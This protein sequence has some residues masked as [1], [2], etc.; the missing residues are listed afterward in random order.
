MKLKLE[1]QRFNSSNQTTH[2]ELSQYTANDKPTYLIDYN[3]DM[4]KIDTAIYGADARSQVNAGAIGDLTTLETTAKSDL[5]SAVN[6]IKSATDTNTSNIATNTS[7]ISTLGGNIG[8]MANLTTTDK[9]SLVGAINEVDAVNQTQNTNITANTNNINT[10]QTEINKFNLSNVETVSAN[11]CTLTNCS[12]TGGSGF[13]VISNSDGSLAKIYGDIFL[14]TGANNNASSVAF[15]SSLRP[16][17]TLTIR[18][19]GINIWQA[20]ANNV[21]YT[22]PNYITI[23]TDGKITIHFSNSTSTQSM[24]VY[25]F[26]TLLFIKDFGDTPT[27]NA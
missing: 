22:V 15:N 11:Q 2:Y 21:N 4:S 10:L 19:I 27:N 20:N 25:L 17:E 12:L 7:N 9:T 26:A 5:V 24:R 8:T 3:G 14:T 18:G 6:E 16:S 13:S 23:A 1:I